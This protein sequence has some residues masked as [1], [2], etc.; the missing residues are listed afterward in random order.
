MR[1]A[2]ETTGSHREKRAAAA[3]LVLCVLALA[4][5]LAAIPASSSTAL[6]QRGHVPVGSFG[7]QGSGAGEMKE[8]E[9]VAVNEA[10]GDVYVVDHGNARVDV[11]ESDGKFKFAFGFGVANE[12]H[13]FQIC[14]TVCHAGQPATG[15]GN[16]YNAR[17][18]AIDNSTNPSDPS[19]GDVYVEVPP[20]ETTL[21][22]K[23]IERELGAI[24]KFTADGKTAE[25]GALIQSWRLEGSKEEIE[26]PMGI[27]VDSAG[28][29]YLYDEEELVVK[30]DD[31]AP[32]KTLGVTEIEPEE[33]KP[34][35]ALDTAGN[36]YAG[37]AFPGSNTF[38]TQYP[39]EFSEYLPH[40][41]EPVLDTIYDKA[42][43]GIA[44]DHAKGDFVLGN[45]KS[46]GVLNAEK[47][48]VETLGEGEL[49]RSS[50]V[51]VDSKTE[52]IYA[53]DEATGKVLDF[54]PEGPGKPTFG[55][56]STSNTTG[57]ST[58][59]SA[60]I[61]PTGGQEAEYSIRASTEP[62][63][64]PESP[65][66]SP[67]VESP[68]APLGSE[69]FEEVH[70]G[71]VKLEGLTPET[72]YH[73]RVFAQNRVGATTL[74]AESQESFFTTLYAPGSTLPDGRSWEQVSPVNKN[75]S[76]L[77][78]NPPTEGGIM[79]ASADGEAITYVG[80]GAISNTEG[81]PE[82]E[83]NA[84]PYLT[85][86]FGRWSPTGWSA[87]DLDIP[88]EEAEGVIPGKGNGY[89]LFSEDLGLG[90]LQ[91]ISLTPLEKPPL[92]GAEGQE[93]TPY[94]RSQQPECLT[95]PAPP[96]CF[97]ALANAGNTTHPFGG[98]GSEIATVNFA[99]GNASLS[100]VVLEATGA[101]TA[102][103][104]TGKGNLYERA[105]A[106]PGAL[107]LASLL[108]NET[109][110]AKAVLGSG[111]LR[112][113]QGAVSEDGS[114]VFFSTP[115]E[116]GSATTHLYMRDTALKKTIRLDVQE[117]G[118]TIPPALYPGT[119][120][121]WETANFSLATPDGSVVFFT[122]QW[123]L[124]PDSQASANQPDLYSCHIEEVAGEPKCKLKDLTVSGN[125]EE[126]AG[127]QGVIG[128]GTN[129]SGT[130]VYY[131]ANAQL[132]AGAEPSKC[133]PGAAW[134]LK[135]KEESEPGVEI[136]ARPVGRL[137]NLYVQRFNAEKGNWETPKLIA[138]L[139]AED[140]L[141]W[142]QVVAG[143]AFGNRGPLSTLTSRVSPD[144]EWLSLMSDRN[145]TGY[146][147]RSV[148]TG[149]GAEEV[150]GYDRAAG[151]LACVSCNPSGGRPH[152]VFDTNFAGEGI[153]M[154]IDRSFLWLDR[155]ISAD[156]PPWTKYELTIAL[157]QSR[158]VD[159]QGRV[160][161]NSVE[162]LVPQDTNGQPDVYEWEPS[163]VGGCT[164]TAETYTEAFSEGL[165]GCISMVSSG[166]SD[167]ASTFLD[168]SAD[169]NDVFFL[170]SGKLVPR[171]EDTSFDVY[172]AAVCG[173]EGTRPCLP[174]REAT[175][176]VCT[177]LKTCR[178][179]EGEVSTTPTFAPP[180]TGA[181]SGPGNTGKSEVLPSKEEGKSKAPAT[182]KKPLTRAQK[183][184][185]AL[186]A[187]KKIKSHTKRVACEH[188]ARKKYGAKKS[189]HKSNV[190]K[191]S[192]SAR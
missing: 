96:S 5:A 64:G 65:C 116:G 95:S 115:G 40:G 107:E 75:G 153:G 10:T 62:V 16:L 186:K 112:S 102:Q 124:T 23:E 52:H 49:T 63:P 79:Q 130:S 101:L 182:T 12:E 57:T 18:I 82:P 103:A 8:P 48:L 170:T 94:L 176:P 188:S 122:D 147:A 104:V 70:V 172:D 131:V 42:S 78:P 50:G 44:Y 114:R 53:A 135:E 108:P 58:E 32:N 3:R 184:S 74:T 129:S 92:N 47:Q 145:L 11:F 164:P 13:T 121:N 1:E 144:G 157:Y 140:E 162:G 67:C 56:S 51:A 136:E 183:L 117:P 66:V 149:R 181:A 43:S 21:G 68:L 7:K 139:S 152:S 185:K 125:A 180:T 15:K 190:H 174:E 160:F 173:R 6:S 69:G 41:E 19:K 90:L 146:D 163:G 77:Q 99:G 178:P 155:Q 88:R 87:H 100:H 166:K 134:E 154:Q 26:E 83:G 29:L 123:R 118:V 28:N 128:A 142:A 84:A 138:R 72:H 191:S 33:G 55:P 86:I 39:T 37:N 109:P 60:A 167:R 151:K 189:S 97:N 36:I 91:K 106:A 171:D 25:K 156:V 46:V 80:S 81:N 85:Q 158:Y 133:V 14:T 169:G 76:A 4:A 168:A 45:I 175:T 105:A 31:G 61:N 111:P 119:L 132:A 34:G 22:K 126:R 179:A 143:T 35:L 165:G 89:R 9:G 177:E 98:G 38:H 148:S 159:D 93:R 71:P 30:F 54:G 150:Y 2:G 24:M 113:V 187:C 17:E 137:C 20:F 127:V 73:Y 192:G 59:I 161:F 141:D 27:T 110:A 120:S